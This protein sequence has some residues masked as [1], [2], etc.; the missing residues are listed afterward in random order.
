MAVSVRR[1]R[2]VVVVV[3]VVSER[4]QRRVVVVGRASVGEEK[5]AECLCTR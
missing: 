3:V 1:K 2:G 5:G 4:W